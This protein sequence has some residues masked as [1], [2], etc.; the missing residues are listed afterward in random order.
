MNQDANERDVRENYYFKGPVIGLLLDVAIREKTAQR[1]S[2]DDV[3]RLLYN[4]YYRELQRGFTE[5]EFWAAVA[6]VAGAPLQEMR[7]LVDTTAD[8][9]YDRLLAPAGLCIDTTD[10]SIRKVANPTPSQ[11][12]FLKAMSL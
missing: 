5:E 9:D 10:W 6:E 1:Q 8:I 12:A 3:M 2:L 11:Q 4:R 7:H